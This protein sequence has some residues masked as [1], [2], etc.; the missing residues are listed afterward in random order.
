MNDFQ[1][2]LEDIDRNLSKFD[3]PLTE[4]DS[5][6]IPSQ[7]IT[8][9]TS[10]HNIRK[11]QYPTSHPKCHTTSSHN[12]QELHYPTSHPKCPSTSPISP[13][14][15]SDISNLKISPQKKKDNPTLTHNNIP[16]QYHAIP[17]KNSTTTLTPPIPPSDTPILN[18]TP[19]NK[20][21]LTTLKCILRKGGE[22]TPDTFEILGQKRPASNHADHTGLPNK[23]IVV[24]QSGKENVQILAEAVQQPC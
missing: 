24:S 2:V 8:P 9:P 14:L 23:K 15:L 18:I 3:L 19:Q 13:I 4:K 5:Y 20:A 22:P 17:S 7:N 1:I 16:A 21:N 10:S 12:I 6:N 11:T